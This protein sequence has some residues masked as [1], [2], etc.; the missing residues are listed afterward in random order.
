[1]S[2]EGELGVNVAALET[3]ILSYLW[4]GLSA[5]FQNYR[6]HMSFSVGFYSCIFKPKFNGYILMTMSYTIFPFLQPPFHFLNTKLMF[7]LTLYTPN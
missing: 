2:L 5:V 7:E 3:L 4:F 6:S 1:M